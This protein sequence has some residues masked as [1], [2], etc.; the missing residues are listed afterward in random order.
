[1]TLFVS[2]CVIILIVPVK[3][4]ERET[5]RTALPATVT[6]SFN[7]RIFGINQPGKKAMTEHQTIPFTQ[8]EKGTLSHRAMGWFEEGMKNDA[9]RK[10]NRGTRQER[11]KYPLTTHVLLSEWL[12][13]DIMAQ[14]KVQDRRKISG[15]RCT[16]GSKVKKIMVIIE[17]I[18]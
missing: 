7:F 14:E 5:D 18:T 10:A 13:R 16:E 9:T 17:A 2:E 15:I 8:R 3:A 6:V 4:S 1:M 12:K 11:L